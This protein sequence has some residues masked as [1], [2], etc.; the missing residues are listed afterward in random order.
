MAQVANESGVSVMDIMQ[1]MK[2]A[3]DKAIGEE[4]DRCYEQAKNIR[5]FTSYTEY[6]RSPLEDIQA[7][8]KAYPTWDKIVEGSV[9]HPIDD[10][11]RLLEGG[12]DV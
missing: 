9:V 4:I 2:E 10:P 8:A 11:A 1:A 6:D 3:L 5:P 7:Y 12:K